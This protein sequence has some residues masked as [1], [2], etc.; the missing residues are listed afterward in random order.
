MIALRLAA[1]G[2]LIA[3]AV[4]LSMWLFSRDRRYLGYAWKIIRLAILA[5]LVFF[6]IY[7]LERVL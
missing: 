7:I 3:V 1:I 2:V 4:L 5:A 6:G